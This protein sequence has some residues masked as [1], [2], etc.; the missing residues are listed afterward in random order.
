MSSRTRTMY[1]R[2][3]NCSM[4]QPPGCLSHNVAFIPVRVLGAQVV[5]KHRSSPGIHVAG[6]AEPRGPTHSANDERH[7]VAHRLNHQPTL[8]LFGWHA[9]ILAIANRQYN[10]A[11]EL[12]QFQLEMEATYRQESECPGGRCGG[13]GVGC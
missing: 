6:H 3:S 13:S 12:E 8:G 1:R 10:G 7:I 2:R 4:R 5:E 11:A 9:H